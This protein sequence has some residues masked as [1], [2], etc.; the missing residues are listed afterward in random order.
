M[1]MAGGRPGPGQAGGARH[2]T[3]LH[4][5]RWVHAAGYFQ[6]AWIDNAVLAQLKALVPILPSIIRQILRVIYA[7]RKAS[8]RFPS[9]SQ[10][11]GLP[12]HHPGLRLHVSLARGPGQE[13]W[14]PQTRLPRLSYR[15]LVR[16]TAETLGIPLAGSRI[17]A[18]HLGTGGSSAVAVKDGKSVDTSMG[19]TALSGWS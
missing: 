13:V 2:Q 9:T 6:T 7:C 8:P 19:Y 12:L 10:P 18:C 5:H 16:K 3:R 14:V 11:T 1:T 4:R 17:V 15:Y